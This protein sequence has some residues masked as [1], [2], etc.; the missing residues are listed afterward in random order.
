VSVIASVAA[1]ATVTTIAFRMMTP[2]LI[3][4]V[5]GGYQR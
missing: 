1:I 4:S 5:P 3:W 2:Q